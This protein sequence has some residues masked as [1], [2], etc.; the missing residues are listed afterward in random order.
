MHRESSINGIQGK[1]QSKT[2][3]KPE[4]ITGKITTNHTEIKNIFNNCFLNVAYLDHPLPKDEPRSIPVMEPMSSV[5][6]CSVNEEEVEKTIKKFEPE[7]SNET[8]SLRFGF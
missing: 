8:T 4:I 3:Q 6:L 5:A 1:Y 2:R 7:K